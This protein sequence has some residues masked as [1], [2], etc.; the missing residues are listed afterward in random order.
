MPGLSLKDSMT[1]GRGLTLRC[2][3]LDGKKD[4][5]ISRRYIALILSPGWFFFLNADSFIPAQDSDLVIEKLG[6]SVF[7]H[8]L[9]QF[10]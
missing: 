2:S 7:F 4:S 8:T 10:C 5:Q 3:Q 6:L 1:Q 9:T